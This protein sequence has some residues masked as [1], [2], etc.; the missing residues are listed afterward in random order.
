VPLGIF[1]YVL[2][3]RL[4]EETTFIG[5]SGK[6]LQANKEVSTVI[7]T[8]CLFVLGDMLDD[9]IFDQLPLSRLDKD[10]RCARKALAMKCG[11]YSVALSLAIAAKKYEGTRIQV[12]NEM[13]KF[14]RSL[15]CLSLIL[16]V[17]NVYEAN[18]L[19]ASDLLLG[20]VGLFGLYVWLKASHMRNIYQLVVNSLV[21]DQHYTVYDLDLPKENRVRLFFWKGVLVSSGT[22]VDSNKAG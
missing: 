15:A 13:A 4:P 22:R 1:C 7:A 19:L 2:L 12:K 11:Y 18:C 16:C 5:I 20:A 8:A 17:F 6:W 10:R 3:S 21:P 9:L 14:S